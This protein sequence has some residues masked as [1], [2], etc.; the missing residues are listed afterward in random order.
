L[1]LRQRFLTRAAGDPTKAAVCLAR[2]LMA[3]DASV[4][5]AGYS[6]INAVIAATEL[7]PE[8][9]VDAI[10]RGIDAG[11]DDRAARRARLVEHFAVAPWAAHARRG[12]HPPPALEAGDLSEPIRRYAAVSGIDDGED[13]H[14]STF[15]DLDGAFDALADSILEGD[16]PDG[17]YDLDTGTKIDIHVSTPVVTASQDQGVTVNPLERSRA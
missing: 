2:A 16:A 8:V 15:D 6:Q 9:D 10:H 13:A 11:L 14:L 7:F 3:G 5:K 1:S 12:D 17:V 4:F